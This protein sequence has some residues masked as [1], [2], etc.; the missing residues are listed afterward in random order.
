MRS[1]LI[2]GL[3][4]VLPG[5]AGAEPPAPVEAPEGVLTYAMFEGAV[6]HVDL[7]QCP[8][9]LAGDDRFCRLTLAESGLTVWAFSLQGNQNLLSVLALDPEAEGGLRF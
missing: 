7:A 9:R 6:P 1:F 8:E 2:A 3:V 4:V 5:F